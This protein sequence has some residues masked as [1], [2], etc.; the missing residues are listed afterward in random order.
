MKYK[1]NEVKIYGNITNSTVNGILPDSE[2]KI[3]LSVKQVYT[4]QN[5]KA[6]K[7]ACQVANPFSIAGDN[8][9]INPSLSPV[10]DKY[11][12]RLRINIIAF[13]KIPQI[14]PTWCF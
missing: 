7:K 11:P 8:D 6:L 12:L 13:A 5:T 14:S 10:T 1:K 9:S 3:V 2:T 4:I